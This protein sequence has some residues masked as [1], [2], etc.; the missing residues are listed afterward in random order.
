M[1]ITVR[2]LKGYAH[3]LTYAVPASWPS[4]NLVGALVQ[5]PLR[6]SII[7]AVVLS[8]NAERPSGSFTIKEA[9]SIEK[10]PHDPYYQQF[11]AQLSTYYQLESS[12][13]IKRLRNF[14]TQK[15]QPAPDV[16]P[17]TE[18]STAIPP[19]ELTHEQQAVVTALEPCIAAQRFSVHVL[20]G[21]TGSG[22]TEIYKKLITHALGQRTSVL[23]LLPEVSLALNFQK[24]LQ[25][26]MPHISLFGFHSSS[27][28]KEK[29]QLWQALIAGKPILIIGVHLP[30]LLPIE[31]LGL[32]IVDEEHDI[33]FQEKKHPKINSKEAALLRARLTQIPVLLG[34]A[35]PS[36][37]SLYNVETRG[38]HLHALTKRFAGSFPHIRVVS[39]RSSYRTNFWISRELEKALSDRLAQGQQSILFLNRRGYSF[40]IQCKQC[41]HI[42]MCPH[43]SVSLTL[44]GN[45]TLSCHYCGLVHPVP[46]ACPSCKATAFLKK[47]IG[48]QQ[49]VEIIQTLFPQARIGRADLDTT[50]NKKQWQATLQAMHDGSLDILIGTQT[51]TKGYHFPR[52]TLVGILWADLNLNFPIFNAQETALQQLI[53]VAGRAGRFYHDS[54]VIVQTMMNHPVF[55]YLNEIDYRRFYE[56]EIKRRK[57]LCYPPYMRLI[58]LELKNISEDVVEREAHLIA[59]RLM[60]KLPAS[61]MVLGPA[62][63]PVHKIKNSFARKIYIKGPDII[64]LIQFF[65]GIQK[66]DIQSALFF[67]P[68]P[69][70]L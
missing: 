53:Q 44:H 57:A 52:V 17:T 58:E 50:V 12:Q 8:L 47:G 35:T 32:I 63:P 23:L 49:L 22:K 65:N 46:I 6:N 30:V 56:E 28:V 69:Q 37:A 39:L 31:R 15:E 38:W 61:V 14:L 13:L 55:N 70:T 19:V 7:P 62:K 3:Q 5:V 43:C 59:T 36:I 60:E 9:H 18:S 2:L 27:S 11:L 54:Q 29:R 4:G 48:T 67:T 64:A 25:Q 34:S 1:Y 68:N 21:V 45:N 24:L 10:F 16:F 26:H 20:H 51:I 66:D 40:F 41:A 33:G 42:I